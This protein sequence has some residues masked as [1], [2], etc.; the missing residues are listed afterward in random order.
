MPTLCELIDI[1]NLALCRLHGMQPFRYDGSVPPSRRG[2]VQDA[3]AAPSNYQ[4]LLITIGAGGVGLNLT[5][6]FIMLQCEEMWN[7]NAFAQAVSR[8]HRQGAKQQVWVIMFKLQSA[9][10]AEITRTR[11]RKTA[12]NEELLAP[13]ILRHDQKPVI[14]PLMY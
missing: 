5:C 14:P 7:E 8:L 11:T 4:P 3:F 9:I 6:A 1:I 12:V 13:L 10:D 2:A